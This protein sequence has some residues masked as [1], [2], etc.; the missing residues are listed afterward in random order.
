MTEGHAVAEME[1]RPVERLVFFTDA[2]VAI[3]LTLLILPLMEDVGEATAH[4]A[5]TYEYL[6]DNVDPLIRFVVSF[7][8]IARYWRLHDTVFRHAEYEVPGLFGL[9]MAWLL[10]IVFL[11]VATALVGSAAPD[12]VQYVLY[13]GTILAAS[14][15]LTVMVIRFRADPSSWK[16]GH[17]LPASFVT[18]CRV[19][20]TLIAI[21]LVITMIFPAIGYLSLVL[22]VLSG[23][24]TKLVSRRRS[25]LDRSQTD[26]HASDGTT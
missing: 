18:G 10:C 3:A 20:S 15:L 19:A 1:R 6:A 4:G 22:L 24:L 11:P 8:I 16:K 25:T 23:R 17:E 14:L 12:R 9:D 13:I 5:D 21:A 26:G 7:A 2:A